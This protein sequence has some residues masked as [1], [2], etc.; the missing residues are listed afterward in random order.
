MNERIPE[1]SPPAKLAEPAVQIP[2]AWQVPEVFRQ[3]LGQRVGRQRMMQAEGHLLL[4]LHAPPGPDDDSRTGRLLW[5]DPQGHWQPR[6]LRHSANA[7]DELLIEYQQALDKIDL[8]EEVATSSRDYFEVL[9]QLNPLGRALNNVHQVLQEAREAFSDAR[10]LILARDN[11]YAL[12][13]RADLLHKEA[14]HSLD[15]EMAR[16]AERQAESSHQ[17]AVSSYRLNL[18]AAFFFPLATLGGIFGMNFSHGSEAWESA[19]APWPLV[20]V[21]AA[22]LVAGLLLTTFVTAPIRKRND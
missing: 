20:G 12:S 16:Q 21:V 9:R 5:R 15:F 14:Q 2:P 22:G 1:T 8:A 13:R 4:V 7:L 10:E 19:N 17:M 11:A 6:G 3:R 18:L